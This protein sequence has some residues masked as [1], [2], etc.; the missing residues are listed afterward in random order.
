MPRS[1]GAGLAR[2]AK[3]HLAPAVRHPP[4]VDV[5]HANLNDPSGAGHFARP[6]R[7]FPGEI[8]TMGAT[9]LA[10]SRRANWNHG[11][12]SRAAIEERRQARREL[13]ALVRL[14]REIDGTP[15]VAATDRPARET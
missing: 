6:F 8:K 13:R 3:R 15:Q 2:T 11:R 9:P 5:S 1:Q 14:V 12:Y 10:R 7:C 4:Y